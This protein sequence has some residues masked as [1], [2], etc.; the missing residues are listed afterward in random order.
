[1]AEMN[2]GPASTTEKIVPPMHDAYYKARKLYIFFSLLLFGSEL[3]GLVGIDIKKVIEYITKIEVKDFKNP[4]ALAWGY[5]FLWT[6]SAI[7]FGIEWSQVELNRRKNIA[8]KWDLWVTHSIAIIA[9][10]V[11]GVQHISD[12]QLAKAPLEF[13]LPFFVGLLLPLILN[14]Y[15]RSKQDKFSEKL[16]KRYKAIFIVLCITAL[17]FTLTYILLFIKN[18]S[19]ITI[20]AL[21]G[22]FLIGLVKNALDR[23][24]PFSISSDSESE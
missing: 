18:I 22:A 21:T 17:V 23:A 15:E 6:Y 10:I 13:L 11:W 8:S 16:K 4:R 9:G 5:F 19:L 24:F 3:I 2:S 20:L 1:M 12:Y 14:F 7:R